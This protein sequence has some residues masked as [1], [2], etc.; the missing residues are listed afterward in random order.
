ML[1]RALNQRGNKLRAIVLHYAPCAQKAVLCI[2]HGAL[3][4][5][6]EHIL[7]TLQAAATVLGLSPGSAKLREVLLTLKERLF[8]CNPSYIVPR[9]TYLCKQYDMVGSTA[10]TALKQNVCSVS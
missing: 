5:S 7:E 9:V 8:T 6:F 4:Y 2:H 3:H 1:I 10:Q